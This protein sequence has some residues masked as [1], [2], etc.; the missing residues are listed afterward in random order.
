MAFKNPLLMGNGF[1]GMVVGG[2]LVLGA[3]FYWPGSF[4]SQTTA[5]KMVASG[6][7]EAV[8]AAFAPS[9][10]AKFKASGDDLAAFKKQ[11]SWERRSTLTN[12]KYA[13]DSDI[14]S[15]CA[16]LLD[17]EPEAKS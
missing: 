1:G 15:A 11:S 8:A 13:P 3:L 2:A 17:K 10:V 12:K 9:C 16:D 7:T 14:A 4:V 5:G 6:K